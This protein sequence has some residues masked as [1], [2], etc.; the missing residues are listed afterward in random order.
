MF[1]PHPR[2]VARLIAS[3]LLC[4][5]ILTVASAAIPPTPNEYTLREWHEQDGLPSDELTGV[6]Q[7]AQGFLWVATSTGLA[8]FDGA[9][10]E[11]AEF[12]PGGIPRG[13]I[14]VPGDAG[15][16][17]GSLVIPGNQATERTAGYFQLRE[18]SFRFMPERELSGRLAQTIFAERDGSLWLGCDDGALFRRRGEETQVF[19]PPA[20]LDPKKGP[21]FAT[22]KTGQVWILRGNRLDRQVAGRLEEFTLARP[23][24]ELRIASSATG[25]VWLF[26]R[27]ALWRWNGTAFEEIVALPERQGAHFIQAAIEDSHGYLWVATRSQGLFRIVGRDILHVTTSSE[28]VVGLCE[29]SEG[30]LWAAC[31][32]GGL[33]RLRARAHRLIDQSSGLKDNY[34]YTVAE[35]AA[36]AIWLANRDGGMVRIANGVIDPVSARTGWRAF[37][38][39]SVHPSTDGKVWMTGGIGVFR[40]NATTPE[41]T[42]RIAP[43]NALR[44]VR[45]TFVAHNGDYWLAA[46]PDRIVRWRDGQLT[47]FGPGE[48]FD[49]REV[50]AFAEDSFGRLWVGAADGRLFRSNGDRFERVLFSRSDSCGALQVIRFESDGTILLGTTRRGVV[51][52]P[53]GDLSRMRMLDTSR[54]LP[55]NNVSQILHDDFER[56]WFATRTGVFWIHESH[57]LEFTAGRAESVH[58]VVLGKDDNLPYL[59]CLGLYQPAAWKASNGT[60]WFT[61]R[62]GVL[63]TDPALVNSSSS[64]PP[65]VALASITCDGRNQ[66]LQPELRI[67]SLARKT[68]IRLS[69][70]NLSAPE[71]VQVRYRLEN[72]DSDWLILDHT[73][74]ITY[75]RLPPGSYTLNTMASN[76]SGLW[77]SQPSLLS[78]IVI[79]PWWQTPWA[80]LAGV[81]GLAVLVGIVVRHRSHRRLRRR[82]EHSESARIIER[83]RTRIARTIHDDLGASLTRISL[84]T[85]TAQ[86]ENATHSPVIEKIYEATRAIT[87]SMDEIVWAVN[88]EQD[89]TESL[90]Y[91][92]GNFAQNFL[93][94]AGIRCRLESPGNLPAAPL[95]S[96]IRHHLFLCCKEALNNLVKHAQATEVTIRVTTDRTTLTIAIADNGRGIAAPAHV[97]ANPLRADSGHGLKNLQQRMNEINGTCLITSGATGGTTVTFTVPLIVPSAI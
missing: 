31:N 76:G 2:P 36:G 13:L 54:G 10:F 64:A 92:L 34:S 41:S 3:A 83:E 67:S 30:N 69:A 24:P 50:R 6:Q 28:N 55:S 85:Q 44:S 18:G 7:D 75:P 68:Q 12:P 73:R 47:T 62:R 60:L 84:L 61:T 49:A 22:D 88:P 32:G 27:T 86:Q 46:D 33:N 35:D 14:R 63:R 74:L 1:P 26:T 77:S 37:S 43:L 42:E 52:F 89:H 79:P 96:Q 91:Y 25:G 4:V 87:R 19:A 59:S 97:S 9:A 15:E 21:A 23:E 65:P 5:V 53:G 58:A 82:L 81:I 56:V 38:A 51:V 72:F 17:E 57:L 11:P 94:A 93:G 20:N 90:V 70:L 78:I 8:R 40:T 45:A 95:T 29:D 66:P 80:Q 39:M 16:K 71:S 48:G